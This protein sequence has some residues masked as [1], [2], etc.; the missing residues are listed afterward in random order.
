V[1]TDR[2]EKYNEE[3]HIDN[4]LISYR[5]PGRRGHSGRGPRRSPGWSGQ[6]GSRQR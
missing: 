4:S 3:R 1:R 5:T 2:C 6:R